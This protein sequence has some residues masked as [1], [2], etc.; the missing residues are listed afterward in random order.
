MTLVLADLD[1][2]FRCLYKKSLSTIP[3]GLFWNIIYSNY[4]IFFKY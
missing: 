2:F 4:S 1:G 3:K